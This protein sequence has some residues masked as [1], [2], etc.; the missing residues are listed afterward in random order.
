MRTDHVFIMAPPRSGTRM[1]T[2]AL[3]R[4]PET[5]LITE[6]KKKRIYIPEEHNQ[7]P[8][9]EFWVRAFGLPDLPLEEVE[10]DATAFA[11]INRM[12]TEGAGS[13]RLVIKNPNNIVR[14]KE[15]RR[16]FPDAQFVWLLRNPWA[17]IQ[18]MMGGPEAGRKNPMFLGAGEVLRHPDPVLRAAVSW[19]YSVQI[20][21]DLMRPSDIITR[22]E[23]L[24]E[25]PRDEIARI[26]ENLSIKIGEAAFEVPE[27]R[28]DDFAVARYVLRR[29]PARAQILQVITPLIQQLGY[30]VTPSGSLREDCLL[31]AKYF[32]TWLKRPDRLPPY[33]YRTIQQL[34]KAAGGN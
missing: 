5:Y 27:R 1:L 15:I 29:S 12:W 9:R 28:S 6:H 19:A 2:R 32:V 11:R 34:R 7:V 3:G 22:Y 14:A 25:N 23:Y 13:K 4:S 21:N 30:P 31:A 10:F 26:A 18:S 20:M 16:A 24:V 8:D 17:V 33:G